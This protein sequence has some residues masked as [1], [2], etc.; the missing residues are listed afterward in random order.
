MQNPRFSDQFNW[1]SNQKQYV[2]QIMELATE[3]R[4][5]EEELLGLIH[6]YKEQIYDLNQ[7]LKEVYKNQQNCVAEIH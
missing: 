2:T 3:N 4:E 5:R 7:N 1:N 6:S